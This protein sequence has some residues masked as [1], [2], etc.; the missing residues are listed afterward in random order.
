MAKAPSPVSGRLQVALGASVRP[1]TRAR[2]G[3]RRCLRPG[4][5]TPVPDSACLGPAGTPAAGPAACPPAVLASRTPGHTHVHPRSAGLPSLPGILPDA[6]PAPPDLRSLTGAEAS[7][8]PV[9]RPVARAPSRGHSPAFSRTRASPVLTDGWMDG[10]CS[11]PP[12]HHQACS[13]RTVAGRQS[14]KNVLCLN[15]TYTTVPA[16]KK[17]MQ[18]TKYKQGKNDGLKLS[19]LCCIFSKTREYLY[20][21]VSFSTVV[22][23]RAQSLF[24]RLD[25]CKFDNG[26]VVIDPFLLVTFSPR[27][28]TCAIYFCPLLVKGHFLLNCILVITHKATD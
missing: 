13:E 28:A 3:P 12:P 21:H 24:L 25:V 16:K 26:F 22:S 8:S 27:P 23:V 11:A 15:F 18:S 17:A 4:A 9:P 2:L 7:R 10:S 20:Q 5:R 19:L 6:P 1:A 14:R